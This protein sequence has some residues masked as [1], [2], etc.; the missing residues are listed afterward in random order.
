MPQRNWAAKALFG[1]LLA[2]LTAASAFAQS[3]DDLK[4]KAAAGD[5]A[6]MTQLADKFFNG[7]GTAQDYAAA[8]KW[9]RMSAERGDETGML[10]LGFMYFNGR[11]TDRDYAEACYWLGLS[12]AAGTDHA[13]DAKK[14]V[15]E[16]EAGLSPDELK[17]VQSRIAEWKKAHPANP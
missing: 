4:Q 16:A 17:K 14:A 12:I 15:A 5:V 11:G 10:N 13:G 7:D 9:Y 8:L 6:A 1:F 3:V 2:L